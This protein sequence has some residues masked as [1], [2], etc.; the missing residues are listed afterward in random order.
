[1][2]FVTDIAFYENP[3]R[4]LIID[5]DKQDL[6]QAVAGRPREGVALRAWTV[7][8]DAD[9]VEGKG[10]GRVVFLHGRFTYLSTPS[11]HTRAITLDQNPLANME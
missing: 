11:N 2:D 10:R 4:H 3:M 9:F 7:D 6:I 1:M 8:W 5:A